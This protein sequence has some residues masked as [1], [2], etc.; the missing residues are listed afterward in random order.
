MLTRRNVLMRGAAAALCGL[1][2]GSGRA[3]AAPRPL[4]VRMRAKPDGSDMWFDPIG[5]LVE[6]GQIIRWIV[7]RDVHTTTAYHP[8]N[9]NHSLR[10]PESAEPWDSGYLVEPGS[11]FEIALT[12]PG[13][14]D[15]FCAPHE[16]AGMVGRLIVGHPDGPGLLPFDY[17]KAD[18]ARRHLAD[19]PPAAR[20]AFPP[21]ERIMRARIVRRDDS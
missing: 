18:A 5:A 2:A 6:P 10:I 13:V 4:I 9:D 7:E 15:Y 14:Y 11:S 8:R 21:V 1:S 17:F 12:V 20:A 19:V 3:R 16:Q